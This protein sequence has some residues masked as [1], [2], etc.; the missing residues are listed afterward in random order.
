M[1]I[2]LKNLTPSEYKHPFDAKA[3]DSLRSTNIIGNVISKIYEL[4]LDK[5]LRHQFLGQSIRMS[6]VNFPTQ[7]EILE[8]ACET[9]NYSERPQ[10][11][12][13]RELGFNCEV[14]GIDKGIIILGTSCIEQLTEEELLFVLGQQIGHFQNQHIKYTELAELLPIIL[15]QLSGVTLGIGG[16]VSSGFQL[17]V[18]EWRQAA[19]YTADR[20]GLLACQNVEAAMRLLLKDAGLPSDCDP[21]LVIDEFKAQS[22][23]FEQINKGVFMKFSKYLTQSKAWEIARAQQLLKWTD[24]GEYLNVLER[25]TQTPTLSDVKFCP[26]CGFK[27]MASPALFCSNCGTKFI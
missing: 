12:V 7:Y 11:Y 4:G 13:M 5:L 6:S 18:I 19:T 26:N 17:A 10:L 8:V 14:L 21:S 23:E 2:P 9:L 1:P 15:D 27:Q 20:A 16:L 25:K 22:Y 3:I 24:S